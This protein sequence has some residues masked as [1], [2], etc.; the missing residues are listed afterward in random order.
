MVFILN[1]IVKVEYPIRNFLLKIEGEIWLIR[2]ID[3]RR[4]SDQIVK[5]LNQ[6]EFEFLY[7]E[8]LLVK[9]SQPK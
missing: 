8:K 1:Y 6:Q 3:S 9:L 7:F 4:R 2:G 5:K